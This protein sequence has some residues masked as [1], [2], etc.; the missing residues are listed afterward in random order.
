MV[1]NC[2]KWD[3]ELK[4]LSTF[5]L[6]MMLDKTIFAQVHQIPRVVNLFETSIK[7]YATKTPV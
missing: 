2:E 3:V 7:T 6:A 5:G 4:Q 1:E